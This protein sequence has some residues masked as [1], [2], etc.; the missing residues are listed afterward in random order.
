MSEWCQKCAHF[1]PA[2]PDRSCDINLRALCHSINEA[3]YPS[4]WQFSNGGEPICTAYSK[5]E[6]PEQRCVDT[7]ELFDN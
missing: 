7:L 1:K 4:E 5:D 2:D 3:E 6:I